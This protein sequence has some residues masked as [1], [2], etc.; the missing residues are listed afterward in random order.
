MLLLL[1]VGSYYAQVFTP[2]YCWVVLSMMHNKVSFTVVL[3]TFIFWTNYFSTFIMISS[4][5]HGGTFTWCL[6][7]SSALV[8]FDMEILLK[9]LKL[10]KQMGPYVQFKVSPCAD[11]PHY[12][13]VSVKII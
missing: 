3:I 11:C 5:D 1:G 9:W 13:L 10:Y 6:G 2:L 12:E 4:F 7:S 8:K